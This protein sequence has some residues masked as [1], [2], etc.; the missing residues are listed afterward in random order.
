MKYEQLYEI[1]ST[2]RSLMNIS[3]EANRKPKPF[4]SD[5][6]IYPA[7]IHYIVAIAESNIVNV[8]ELAKKMA[9]T[10]GAVSQIVNKLQKKD[11]ISRYKKGNDDKTIYLSLTQTGQRVAAEHKR[12]EQAFL[13]KLYMSLSDVTT[14][15]ADNFHE[16]LKKVMSVMQ[17]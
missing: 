4:G 12:L 7:E 14:E 8:T 2:F 3:V 15:E 10:K 17:E 13:D 9:V 11:L 1:A 16:I 5:T 6:L